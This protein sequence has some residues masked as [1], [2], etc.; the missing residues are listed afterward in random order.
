MVYHRNQ[1]DDLKG[2]Y[3]KISKKA[4][5]TGFEF[6]IDTHF[7][8]VLNREVDM[9]E[10]V[11]NFDGED[12]DEDEFE[13]ELWGILGPSWSLVKRIAKKEKCPSQGLHSVRV[14]YSLK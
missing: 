9:F 2:F 12:F 10:N 5:T 14:F 11:D 3:D 7:Y 1:E 6:E 4:D 13:D 8:E